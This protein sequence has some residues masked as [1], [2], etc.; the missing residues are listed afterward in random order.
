MT[1]EKKIPCLET[2]YHL[3]SIERIILYDKVLKISKSEEDEITEF[4]RDEYEKESLHYPFDAPAFDEHAATWAAKVVY[5]STQLL[6]NRTDTAKDL[7]VLLPDYTKEITASVMLSADLCLRFLP[8]IV[9]E[10]KNIDADDIA[11]PILEKKLRLFHY[12]NIGEKHPQTDYDFKVLESNCLKQLY[13]NRITEKKD[14]TLA[15]LPQINKEL[16]SN[17]GDYKAVFWKD[18]N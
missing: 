6:L 16:L 8:V 15:E 18:L 4:L 7:Q 14:K 2:I 12:S 3:R 10:M 9:R 17:F 11:I 13:L 5:F 1:E